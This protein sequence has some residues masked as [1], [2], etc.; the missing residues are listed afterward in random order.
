[1][2]IVWGIFLATLGLCAMDPRGAAQAGCSAIEVREQVEVPSGAVSLADLLSPETC[3]ALLRPAARVPLGQS[4]L[5]GSP[6]VLRGE[7]VRDWIERLEREQSI[8]GIRVRI[9]ERVT[10]RR[11]SA[12]S[13]CLDFAAQMGI[14]GTDSALRPGDEPR[15][16]PTVA[17][18]SCGAP[19]RIAKDAAIQAAAAKWNPPLAGWDISVECMGPGECVPFL[20]RVPGHAFPMTA[21]LPSRRDVSL[22]SHTALL[23]RIGFRPSSGEAIAV[24]RGE[25]VLLEWDASGIRIRLPAVSLDAGVLGGPVHARLEPS[26]RVVEAIVIDHGRLRVSS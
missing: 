12:R 19:D 4:P 6:R 10:I 2:K 17:G 22:K 14:A 13:A 16:R 18:L 8:Y 11:A 20:L 25:K 21:S 24:R 5:V 1:M 9:P 3:D 26:G 7:S 23:A 15:G